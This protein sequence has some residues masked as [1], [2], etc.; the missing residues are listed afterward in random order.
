MPGEQEGE[1][2]R[3]RMLGAVALA[4]TLISGAAVARDI[5]AD[6]LTIDD[7]VAWL[8]SAGYQT[9]LIPD[10]DGTSHIRS[11]IGGVRLGVYMF[12]CK[13][14]R[15]GSLQFSAGWATH[16]KFDV[17]HMNDWN[18]EQRWAR[19]YFD[20]ENDPWVE[21]DADLTPGGTYELLNDEF[22]IYKKA[23][24]NFTARYGL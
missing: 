1:I 17:T 21:L 3:M 5:P 12:D 7:V 13:N 20:A 18:R 14:G 11:A 24:S 2:M 6:G 16:G 19:G 10:K 4:L 23:V 8:Q 15:C 9:E 22:A